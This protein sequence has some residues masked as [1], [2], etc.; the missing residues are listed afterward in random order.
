VHLFI[1]LIVPAVGLF[2]LWGVVIGPPEERGHWRNIA[3]LIAGMVTGFALFFALFAFIDSQPTPTNFYATTVIPSRDIWKLEESD[4]DSIPERFWLSF[5]GYQWRD[6]MLPAGIDYN[7]IVGTFFNEYLPRQYNRG[8]LALAAIGALAMLVW[9]RRMLLLFGGTLVVAFGIGLVYHPGDKHL[10]YLPVY[11]MLAVLIAAGAGFLIMQALRFLPKSLPRAI[12]ELALSLLLLTLCIFAMLP[13]R[14]NAIQAG[15]AT[16]VTEDYI[17]PVGLLHEPRANATCALS[18]IPEEN[19]L[20]VLGW[21]AAYTTYYIAHV[22][23]GRTGIIIHEAR[24]HGTHV[25]TPLLKAEVTERLK[26]G[27]A[28][29]IDFDDLWQGFDMERVPGD[30][31]SYSLLKLALPG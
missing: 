9:Q 16:F 13:S 11:L 17:Y 19:A 12:P 24:P 3:R 6:A 29:Y 23:Q 1:M 2:V 8:A 25:I 30:C 22:E 14:I 7:E 18:K 31:Q 26:N 4:L 28:V 27:E 10:F 15:E 20:L 21:R 5:S